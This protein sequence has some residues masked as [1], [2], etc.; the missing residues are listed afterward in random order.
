M[1][2]AFAKDLRKR[3]KEYV[4]PPLAQQIAERGAH[5][6]APDRLAGPVERQPGTTG[7]GLVDRPGRSEHPMDRQPRALA[8]AVQ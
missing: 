6:Q 1:N 2:D 3:E 7:N 8:A 5:G 4:K